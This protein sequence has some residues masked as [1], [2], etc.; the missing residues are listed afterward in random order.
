MNQCPKHV[1]IICPLLCSSYHWNSY[2]GVGR[3]KNDLVE[4]KEHRYVASSVWGW[5]QWL[6]QTHTHTHKYVFKNTN[7]IYQHAGKCDH[8]NKF[9]NI[10]EAS[11]VSNPEWLT[12]NS[13]K[14]TIN[15][16]QVKKPSATKSLCLLTNILD[17][18]KTLLSVKSDILNQGAR[19][20]NQELRCGQTKESKKKV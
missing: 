11:M 14:Y 6:E 9:K 1:P 12:D 10:I 4:C 17:V 16:T 3:L 20:L 5:N 7:K 15:Q 13:T 19:Q 2:F 18:K 8:Q